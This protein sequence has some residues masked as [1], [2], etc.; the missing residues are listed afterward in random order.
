MK[1]QV[2]GGAHPETQRVE[3][4]PDAITLVEKVVAVEPE[5]GRASGLLKSLLAALVQHPGWLWVEE[6]MQ[7][8]RLILEAHVA[9]T[10]LITLTNP[11]VLHLLE[12]LVLK[13]GNIPA[14]GV[15]LQLI[16]ERRPPV[17]LEGEAQEAKAGAPR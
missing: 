7:Q 17:L 6:R 9:V 16:G 1:V 15:T 8:E 4:D 5:P 12:R 2:I 13:Y 10:D 11:P 3:V 14:G